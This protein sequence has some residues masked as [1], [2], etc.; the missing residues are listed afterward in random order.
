MKTHSFPAAVLA[1]VL[2]LAACSDKEPASSPSTGANP[3]ASSGSSTM[4]DCDMQGMDMSKMSAEEH[5]KMMEDCKKGQ[6]R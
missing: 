6:G 5:Q 2:G 1:I 3:A 4:G